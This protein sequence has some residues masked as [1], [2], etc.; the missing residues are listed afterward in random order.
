M[1]LTWSYLMVYQIPFR[2]EEDRL[3]YKYLPLQRKRDLIK[4]KGEKRE[5]KKKKH[6]NTR[7]ERKHQGKEK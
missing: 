7:E 2:A 5:K 4:T 1:I 6:W 3:K